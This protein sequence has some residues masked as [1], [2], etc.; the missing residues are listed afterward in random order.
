MKAII[1]NEEKLDKVIQEI[2]SEIKIG[3]VSLHGD[4]ATDW[5]TVANLRG[6]QYGHG[7]ASKKYSKIA[8]N[9]F[10]DNMNKWEL[11]NK[12]SSGTSEKD[13]HKAALNKSR[14]IVSKFIK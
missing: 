1:L 4:N 2:L 12:D 13:V 9:G 14:N 8:K 5:A 10:R 7:G 6:I 3:G 11:L